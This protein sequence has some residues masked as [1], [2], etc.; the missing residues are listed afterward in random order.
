MNLQGIVTKPLTNECRAKHKKFN[1][2]EL[3]GFKKLITFFDI[4]FHSE[5]FK[6]ILTLPSLLKCGMTYKKSVR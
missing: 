6:I 2:K 4:I 1:I 3:L 5:T